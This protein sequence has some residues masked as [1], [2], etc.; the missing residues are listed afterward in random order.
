[1]TKIRIE[2]R[3]MCKVLYKS[4]KVRIA[5]SECVPLRLKRCYLHVLLILKEY[6]VDKL[7]GLIMVS[8]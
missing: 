3:K 8:E 6:L 1:M 2:D 5:I 7:V 4:E